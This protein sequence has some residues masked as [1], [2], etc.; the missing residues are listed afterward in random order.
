[1]V[2]RDLRL[3][4]IRQPDVACLQWIIRWSP[5][6]EERDLLGGLEEVVD[7]GAIE[8][9]VKPKTPPCSTKLSDETM[10]PRRLPVSDMPLT[11]LVFRRT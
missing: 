7:V 2:G 5:G 8:G 4:V 9:G 6:P 1:V 3:R 10:R 11:T